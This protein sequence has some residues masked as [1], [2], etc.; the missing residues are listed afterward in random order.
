M[1]MLAGGWWDNWRGVRRES[2][3]LM[4]RKQVIGPPML[5]VRRSY[6]V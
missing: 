4:R 2:V 5:K 6:V 3:I 1:S